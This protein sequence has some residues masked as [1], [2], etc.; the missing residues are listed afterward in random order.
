L[1]RFCCGCGFMNI[2]VLTKRLLGCVLRNLS[3]AEAELYA[4]VCCIAAAASA[5][6]QAVQTHALLHEPPGAVSSRPARVVNIIAKAFI[7]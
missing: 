6:H 5:A 2:D 3:K 7:S 1:E 4:R